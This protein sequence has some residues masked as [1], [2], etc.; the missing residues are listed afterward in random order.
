MA[1]PKIY[2]VDEVAEILRV[3]RSTVYRKIDRG[4][5]R[6]SRIGAKQVW[7][8]TETALLEVLG[9]VTA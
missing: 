3:D 4:E 5:L 9:E 2:T 8:I 6:A 7:R 1:L